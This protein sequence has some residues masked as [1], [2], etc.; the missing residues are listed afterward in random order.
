MLRPQSSI[1][2]ENRGHLGCFFENVYS[3]IGIDTEKY[4]WMGFFDILIRCLYYIK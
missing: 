2:A 4:G 3:E 1:L